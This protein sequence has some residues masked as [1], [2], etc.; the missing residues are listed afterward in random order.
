MKVHTDEIR[1]ETEGFCDI[2]DVSAEVGRV[3]A[4]SGIRTGLVCVG[5]PG[6]TTGVTTIEFEPGAVADLKRALESLAPEKGRY[7]HNATWGDGNGFA[8]LRSALVGTSRTFPVRDGA[9]ALGTWQQVVFLDFD[10]RSR[11]R[12]VI[13]TVMGD[14]E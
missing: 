5:C 12:T 2:R 14:S 4:D 8:H 7:D 6:S 9:P 3:V 10:N 11:R 1:L 13:V